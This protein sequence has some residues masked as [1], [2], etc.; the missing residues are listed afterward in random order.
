MLI[1]K[2]TKTFKTILEIISRCQG[3][4]DREK[5][6]RLY[7]TRAGHSISDR[8]SVE[9]IQGDAAL[10]YEMN[11]QSVMNNLQSPSHQ[12]HISDEISGI[13]FFHSSSNKVWD[14]TPFEFDEAIKKEF[15]SLPELPIVRK[16]EKP[17]KFVFPTGKSIADSGGKK[18]EAGGK[19]ERL[20]PK[21][22]A[23]VVPEKGPRQPGYKLR[24]KIHFTDL[25]KVV[26]RDPHLTKQDILDYYNKVAEYIL[27]Y[28]KDRPLWTRLQ[29]GKGQAPVE[30]SVEELFNEDRE[31]LPDWVQSMMISKGKEK[32]K[33]LL[34]ND[35]E[36]LLLY[37]E[38]GCVE[39]CPYHSRTKSIDLPDYIILALNS[40]DAELEKAT[41]VVSALSVVLEGLQLPSFFTSDGISGLH[42]YIPLDSKSAFDTALKVAVYIA[43]LIALKMPERISLNGADDYGYGRVSLDASIN[44]KGAGVVAPY[45]L[46]ASEAVSVATPLPRDSVADMLHQE[47]FNEEKILKSLKQNGDPFQTLFKKKVNADGLLDRLEKNY[48]FLFD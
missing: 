36:H 33:M 31:L 9:G 5:L 40:P 21:K 10:F 23:A 15:S 2:N 8:I 26:F 3:R 16:K 41:D 17:E 14:E 48:A 47:P 12:L 6:I 38:M 46:V 34:C 25:E 27:P 39:F 22:A 29:S 30:L 4:V 32:K 11:Y 19:K 28:L 7:I 24:H 42:V 13:Y 20:S 1:R 45:S 18:S 35:K 37:V 43:R 44:R